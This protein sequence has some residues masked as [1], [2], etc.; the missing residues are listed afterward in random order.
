MIN[1]IKQG[2]VLPEEYDTSEVLV[3][4]NVPLVC[5]RHTLYLWSRGKSHVL[6]T[7]G[8]RVYNHDSSVGKRISLIQRLK[9][10][11]ACVRIP[12]EMN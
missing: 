9:S 6:E 8:V 11:G 7:E 3:E 12:H 5:T 4:E 10:E 1:V 2:A